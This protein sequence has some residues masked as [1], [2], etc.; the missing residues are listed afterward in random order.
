MLWTHPPLRGSIGVGPLRVGS[1]GCPAVIDVLLG[2]GWQLEVNSH[3]QVPSLYLT[4]ATEKV[5]A[6]V[7]WEKALGTGLGLAFS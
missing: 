6:P 2:A 7:F 3:V 4:A 5:A 1:I